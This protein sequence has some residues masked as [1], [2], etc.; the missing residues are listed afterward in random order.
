M[1]DHVESRCQEGPDEAEESLPRQPR[2]S[3]DDRP[4]RD[5]RERPIRVLARDV[6]T[7]LLRRIANVTYR[8]GDRLPSCTSFG[9]EIG[10][11]KNTISKA[12]QALSRRGYLNS[13]PGR[14][15]FV[16]TRPATSSTGRFVDEVQA[17][18]TLVVENAYAAGISVEELETI[19]GDEIRRRYDR[20][21]LRVAFVEC[22][23]AEATKF[24]KQLG[25][26]L[27]TRIEPLLLDDFLADTE[28]HT[29][30]FDVIAVA[31][32]HLADVQEQFRVSGAG[33]AEIFPLLTMPDA[34]A[35]AALARLPSDTRLGV[36]ANTPEAQGTLIGLL[37]AFN[38]RLKLESALIEDSDDVARVVEH[39][40]V[41]L[42][43]EAVHQHLGS[44]LEGKQLIEVP[45]ELDNDAVRMLLRRVAQRRRGVA[46]E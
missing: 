14:G 19:L 28:R 7:I 31:L 12:Y 15:T 13:S 20:S 35:L 34:E 2:Q 40:D 41:V 3:V 45:F 22:N 4:V 17:L 43:T 29:E 10:A 30:E 46:E 36:L 21:R 39:A 1:L 5:P 27:G 24:S 9:R 33:R 44:R 16:T 26:M 25:E 37:H 32:S 11:N 6:E 42:V 23:V 18:L 8:A 38:S